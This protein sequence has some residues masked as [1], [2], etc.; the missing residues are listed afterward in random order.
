MTEPNQGKPKIAV[1]AVH[2]VADQPA[3]D[4]ARA[5]ANLLLNHNQNPP[6]EKKVQYTPFYES[7]LRI[8][9]RPVNV[10]KDSPNLNSRGEGETLPKITDVLD[11]ISHEFIWKQ[12]HKYKHRGVKSTYETVRLEGS[13]L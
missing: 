13:R 9:V 10:C 6:N 7:T 3:H 5:I 4:S 1:I 2:G 12:V 11:K 8:A